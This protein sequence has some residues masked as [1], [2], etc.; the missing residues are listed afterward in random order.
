MQTM[1]AY[2]AAA[3]EAYTEEA[4]R[5]LDQALAQKERD[6]DEISYWRAQLRA[7]TKA[8]HYFSNGVR[9]TPTPTG[10]TLPSASRPGAVVHRLWR[11]GGIWHCSCEAGEKGIFHWHAALIAGYDRALDLADLGDGD[12]GEPIEETPPPPPTLPGIVVTPTESGALAFSR[13]NVTAF[14]TTPEQVA[15]AL[16]QLLSGSADARALGQRIAAARARLAA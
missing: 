8:L 13:G 15:G 6:Q 11:V 16:A 14:V 2:T 4:Q 1:D 12:D 9:L 3:L 10:Y 5:L 7:F